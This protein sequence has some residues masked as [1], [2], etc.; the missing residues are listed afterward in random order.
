[1][2]NLFSL[3]LACTSEMST[4]ADNE[5]VSPNLPR[6]SHAIVP[7][8]FHI[9]FYIVVITYTLPVSCTCYINNY[10]RI[11]FSWSQMHFFPTHQKS[12][13][14]AA[15]FTDG[16]RKNQLLTS[17]SLL[18]LSLKS[19][20]AHIIPAGIQK[21]NISRKVVTIEPRM[22]VAHRLQIAFM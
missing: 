14:Q 8:I 12:V 9:T 22:N 17:P 16:A 2:H 19:C 3:R 15:I 7:F 1:M 20:R 6:G 5:W 13:Q 4:A 21:G 10:G 11:N 18:L